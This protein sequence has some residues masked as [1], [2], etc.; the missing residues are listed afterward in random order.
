MTA[1]HSTGVRGIRY[2]KHPSRKHGVAFD[3]YYFIR[4]QRDGERIEEGCGWASEGWTLEE[5]VEK[6]NGLRKSAKTGEG[7]ARLS[8]K[9]ELVRKEKAKTKREA[10]TLSDYWRDTYWPACEAE[11]TYRTHQR[12]KSL[13]KKWIA[14]VLGALP[15]KAVAPIHLEKIKASMAKVSKGKAGQSPRSIQYALAVIRQL[16]NDARRHGVFLGDNPVRQVRTP[17]IDNRRLRF[18]TREEAETL[19]AALKRE[20]AEAYE[21]S[22][23]SLFC[24]LR[25]SEIFGLTWAAVDTEKGLITVKDAKNGRTRHAF[26]TSAVKEMF[27]A[28]GSGGPADPI[29]PAHRGGKTREAPGTFERVVAELGFNEGVKDRRDKVVF[30]SLR[31]TFA[32][33]LVQSG[34]SL[35]EVKERL[36]HRSI[37]MTER[38]SHL[39][40]E[41]GRGTVAVLE[42]FMQE[43]GRNGNQEKI[44]SSAS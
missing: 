2:R 18:L 41:A 39:A 17:K 36:G 34:V 12:E 23:I 22:L 24:G 7:P 1:Y 16:F 25:A 32:S 28:K 5:A 13:W 29:Y 33:W 4:F 19:L 15:F 40:P 42:N 3:R 44:G 31:H 8:E 9:R 10:V 27:E 43:G 38:Y 11:K 14:P 21:V 6:L 35:Y 26:M 37:S 20:N 30:H